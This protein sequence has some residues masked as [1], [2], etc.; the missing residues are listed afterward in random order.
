MGYGD[1]FA[2]VEMTIEALDLLAAAGSVRYDRLRM[3]DL[4]A[5]EF[6]PG[7]RRIQIKKV[8]SGTADSR[9][10]NR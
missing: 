4:V 8:P 2:P 9:L 6:I 7:M 3:A 1:C 5:R 10:L